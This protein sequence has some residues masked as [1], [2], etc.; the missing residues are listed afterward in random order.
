MSGFWSGW[1]MVLVVVNLGD[2]HASGHVAVPW[3]DLRGGMWELADPTTDA[4]YD[5]SGDELRD[6]LYVGLEPWAWHVFRLTR[7]AA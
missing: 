1:V 2:A 6:G 3:D 7:T 5:R 4:V